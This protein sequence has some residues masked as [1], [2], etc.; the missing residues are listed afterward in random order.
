[1]KFVRGLLFLVSVAVPCSS[2]LAQGGA[3]SSISGVV[4]DS[5]GAVLPG[6]TVIVTSDA[7]GTKFESATNSTGAYTVPA[8][9]AGAYTVTFSLDGFKTR[10]FSDVRVQ[11]AIP[12]TL[13]A[14]L[15]IGEV[16]ETITVSGAGA[17]LINTITPAVTAT[18]N[19]DQV[20]VI[21]TPTR[22][23]LNAVTFLVGVNTSGGMRGSTVNGLPESFLNLTLDGVSNNDTF[24]KNSDGFFSPVRA[25][26]D[27]VEAVTVTTAA[28]GAEVGGH[29]GVTINFVTRSG[30]NRFTGSAYE[31]FRDKTLNS[32]YWFNERNGQPKSDVRLNQFGARQGGPIVRNRAFFFV[33]YEE[34]RN[35]NDASRTRTTL[36][37]RSLDGWFRYNVTV[38]GQ[39]SVREVNVLDLA[40]ANG[41]IA[42]T[43][44]VVM[45]T[46]Q[47]VNDSHRLA[48]SLTPAS[49]PLLMSYFF[50][51]PG[52]QSEKQP[53]LRID[54]NLT[55]R[56]RLTGTYNHFFE[57]RAQDHINGAD[58]RFPGSPNYRQVRTTRPTR[59]IALRSTLSNN[60]VSELRG[61]ITRGERL[62]FGRPERNAPTPATFDDTNGFA[63]ELDANIGLTNWFVTNTLSSRSGYQYTL[64]EKLSWLTGAHSVSIGG[65]AFLGRAW[66]DSQQL[67][68]GVDL[69]F[70]TTNDPAAGLFTNTNFPG[71][72]GAQLTDARELYA[73][74]TGR[75]GAV[76]GQAA[77]DPETNRYTAF[78]RRRRAGKLDVY[79]A[80]LQ[81]SWRATP[82]VIVSA[83]L[84]WDVQMPFAPSNNTM[85][86]ASLA[87]V[88]GA[89]GLG[90]G[91]LYNACNFFA[92]GSLGG[93]VP[94]FAQFTSG[95]RG[96]NTDWNNL[97]PNIGVAWRPNVA[98]GWLRTLL[99]DPEHATLRGG[100]SVAYERQGIGG[101]TGIYGENSGSTLSLTRD[102]NTGLVGPGER[103]PVL[104]RQTGRLYQAPFPETPTYPIPIRPNRADDISAFHPDIEVASA[105]S[106]TVGVQRA[107]TRDMALEAR[108]VGTRGVN[109]W[110]T[111]NYNERN[112]IEN[113]FLDEF[114][115]AMKN[116]QANN[117]AG[118][119][120]AGSFAYFGPGTGT[121][122]LP[123]Y[124]AYLN[125]RRDADNPAAY[126]GGAATWTNPTIAGRFVHTNPNPNFVSATT[127]SAGAATIRNNNA[128]GDLDNN[129]TFRNNALAAGLPANFF[130]VNPHA[131][132]VNVR[133][134]GAF[135]SYHALQF[136]LRR[137]LSRGLSF[138][139]SYQYALE[140]SSEFLGFHFGR[141]SDPSDSSLRHAFKMQWHWTIPVGRDERF[142]RSL[143]PVLGA[144]FGAWQFNGAGRF[145]A[146]TTDFGNVRLVGMSKDDA[147]KLY[148][149][150]IRPDPQ[151]GLPTV[152][153]FPDDVILNTRRA[154]SVSVTNPSG[155]SDLGIPVG[156][157]F[158]PANSA[159]CIQLKA[160]DCAPRALVL[161]APWF[162][163]FDIGLTKKVS[164]GGNKSIEVRADVLNV[165][166]N[167]N[168]TVTDPSRT[169]GAGGGIFQTDSAYRD[170]DNTYD[171]G[172]RLGQI[173]LRFNW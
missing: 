60:L 96:Y 20:A 68:P 166:N 150:E 129:L 47:A 117:I 2:V 16:S 22:N 172:G 115:L 112:V 85:T 145:Q 127:V 151:T 168:F 106:W 87:D 143:N 76:T 53:A 42:T 146:R 160:G 144:L 40:R 93:K 111:L 51:N 102:V 72:S 147:Q 154:F 140:E 67:V 56:H 169:P 39:Q 132:V 15:D 83:G 161:L 10:V 33:H 173:A 54:Y 48:G 91:G 163:R 43:D 73:L 97:A 121:N 123:I 135:N 124:L 108:Y 122:P 125:G 98:G 13:N 52:D 134:S 25:R 77:L 126:T 75:V 61:G 99:G 95:T 100:Y 34:V 14:P 109:Q 31:Y 101:F 41:Q 148:T 50:L 55:D 155:Y 80:Y 38:G 58:K 6:A 110:S 19:V 11:L 86:T 35:P 27:A 119:S 107:L 131:G 24:N 153:A 92:P 142:G 29:G 59:S 90:Q 118:G 57:A 69:R 28:G 62:F 70:D 170:L 128:A 46:L 1:M 162:T 82:T 7:T 63:L 94:E 8:L 79:S 36:H 49:D 152:F 26:Q 167:V 114:K 45:R 165:L 66:E 32:N 120:R 157:Y 113:G 65:S 133:D 18:L 105:R 164:I 81:D 158:A 74:L 9:P 3:T 104:L 156:R 71:A 159:D 4:S 78:G 136:E 88:C 130:V 44:P 64:D 149:W 37:P 23:A 137:R 138:N 141:A 171:P 89:S 5:S 21:P 103:W 30:T 84:R 116:L 17:E 139:G 12:T